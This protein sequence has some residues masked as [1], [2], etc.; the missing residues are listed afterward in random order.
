MKGLRRTLA[1][2]AAAWVFLQVASAAAAPLVL[3]T[4]PVAQGLVQCTCVHGAG[5]VCPMHH[6]PASGPEICLL[7]SG[8]DGATA[9]LTLILGNVGLLPS[10]ARVAAPAVTLAIGVGS[11]AAQSIRPVSPDPPPPRA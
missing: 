9:I 1:P 4:R 8:T 6:E 11:T 7:R 5:D 2:I 10:A 3:W